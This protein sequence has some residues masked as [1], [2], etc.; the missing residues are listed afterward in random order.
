MLG[1]YV[2]ALRYFRHVLVLVPDHE[3]ATQEVKT[4]EKRIAANSER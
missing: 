4:L 2:E 3:E 1:R